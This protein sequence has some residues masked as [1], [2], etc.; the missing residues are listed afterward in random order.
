MVDFE[1][2]FY[3]FG[4]IC[5]DAGSGCGELLFYGPPPEGIMK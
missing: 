2:E 1:R 4:D 5:M 3:S